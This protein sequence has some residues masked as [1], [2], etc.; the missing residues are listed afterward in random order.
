[1]NTLLIATALFIGQADM[2]K[3]PQPQQKMPQRTE[4]YAEQPKKMRMNRYD[5][6]FSWQNLV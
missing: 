5:G 3:K 2:D 6:S 1:M 4:L